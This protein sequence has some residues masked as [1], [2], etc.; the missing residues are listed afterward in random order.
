MLNH[1]VAHGGEARALQRHD[2]D[3]ELHLMPGISV[4]EVFLVEPPLLRWSLL[5]VLTFWLDVVEILCLVQ[6]LFPD[7]PWLRPSMVRS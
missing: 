1:F 2:R 5:T 7:P 6:L 3:G 4:M